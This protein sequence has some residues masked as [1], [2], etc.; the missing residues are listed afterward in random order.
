[1]TDE[2]DVNRLIRLRVLLEKI[3]GNYEEHCTRTNIGLTEEE[4]TAWL[5]SEPV[6]TKRIVKPL[7][8]TRKGH[9][10]LAIILLALVVPHHAV[11]ASSPNEMLQHSKT[12]LPNADVTLPYA[13]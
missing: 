1:M 11:Q 7:D 5:R 8:R 10:I 2:D 13:R 3:L 9:I 12:V 4:K 6:F